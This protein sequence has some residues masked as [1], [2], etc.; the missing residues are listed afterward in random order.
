[1]LTWLFERNGQIIYYIIENVIELVII[2]VSIFFVFFFWGKVFRSYYDG[3]SFSLVFKLCDYVDLLGVHASLQRK[4][5]GYSILMNYN[6]TNEHIW[7]FTI[8]LASVVGK[9]ECE[10]FN[11]FPTSINKNGM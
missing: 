11:F 9:C 2:H 7:W 5:D 1:M 8:V 6:C 4:C 10:I 3:G